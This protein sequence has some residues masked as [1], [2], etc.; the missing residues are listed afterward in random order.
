MYKFKI[1]IALV[2]LIAV[3]STSCKSDHLDGVEDVNNSAKFTVDGKTYNAEKGVSSF[4]DDIKNS[5]GVKIYDVLES[6]TNMYFK[7]WSL[8]NENEIGRTLKFESTDN[9]TFS[10]I[11]LP[12]VGDEAG[13]KYTSYSGSVTFISENEVKLSGCK[14]YEFNSYEVDVQDSIFVD[15][16]GVLLY[17][18]EGIE[19]TYCETKENDAS[20]SW[21]ES[22]RIK[23]GGDIINISGNNNGYY[24]YS[25]YLYKLSQLSW[26]SW[27]LE[28]TPGYKSSSSSFVHWKVFVDSNENGSFED[29]EVV[30]A[31]DIASE[32]VITSPSIKVPHIELGRYKMRVMM[33]V[34]TKA[35]DVND[36]KGCDN[37]GNGEVEDY[38]VNVV[39]Y[40]S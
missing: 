12:T 25:Y 24:D 32:G 7:L 40:N 36:I 14:F 18:S 17:S 1:I 35:D 4:E 39:K 6:K 26:S 5:I 16:E 27:T 3:S 37:V 11:V 34:V 8:L 15:V 20:S 2:M 23:G 30:Y 28:F 22:F 10:E 13:K 29:S 31:T 9:V 19:V 21:I 33:K 38:T